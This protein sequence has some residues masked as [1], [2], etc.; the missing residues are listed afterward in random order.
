MNMAGR[1]CA[2]ILH[3]FGIDGPWPE[4][5]NPDVAIVR[6]RTESSAHLAGPRQLLERAQ[7]RHKNVLCKS[8]SDQIHSWHNISIQTRDV[9][10]FPGIVG[11]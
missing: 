10:S 9:V 3:E 7:T 11:P 5:Q 2:V 1:T 4:H 8:P 6:R